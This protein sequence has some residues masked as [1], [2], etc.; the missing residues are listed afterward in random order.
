VTKAK[1]IGQ[2]QTGCSPMTAHLDSPVLYERRI[3]RL[4]LPYSTPEQLERLAARLDSQN[5]SSETQF[6]AAAIRALLALQREL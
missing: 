5:A 1:R 2:T 4:R 3:G 6:E